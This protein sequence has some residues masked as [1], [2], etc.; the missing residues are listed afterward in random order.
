MNKGMRAGMDGLWIDRQREGSGTDGQRE[1]GR[2]RGRE[3]KKEGWMDRRMD[4]CTY[5]F[6]FLIFSSSAE[7]PRATL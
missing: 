3:R 5:L 4:G 6:F 1:G 2:D 7:I